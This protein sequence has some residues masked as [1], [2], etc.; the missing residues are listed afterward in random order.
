MPALKIRTIHDQE[1][2]LEP[3]QMEELA[4]SF[5]GDVVTPDSPGYDAA[6]SIWNAM[7]DRRPALI[8]RCAGV[9]DILA[10][11]RFA[12]QHR[13]LVSVRGGGHNIAGSALADGALLIDL[14]RMRSV[15]VDPQART[16]RVEPGATLA[17]FDH[18]AQAFGLATPL[19]INSTTG[20]A[21]LTLGGGFGW[22]SRRFG[23][24]IDNLLSAD[25]VTADG[26]LRRASE[27]ENP[28]LFWAIRGGGGNFGVVASFD[29]RLHA[30]GPDV[31]SGLVVHPFS[32]ARS[33]LRQYRGVVGRAPEE[34][35]CWAVLRKAPPLPFLPA[36]WH[37]KEV[38]VLAMAYAGDP[39]DGE[40]VMEPIRAVGHPIADVVGVNP[41]AGWQKAFDP[42]LVPG[43]RNYWKS[44]DLAALSDGAID[45]L[46]DFASRVPSPHCEVFVGHL[47]GA[48]NRVRPEATAF[49]RRDAEFVVNV[50]GRWDTAAE[51]AA[52]VAWCRDLFNALAPH[53]TGAVYV[54]FMTADEGDRVRAAYGTNYDRLMELKARYDPENVFR[55]NQ[56]IRPAVHA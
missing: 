49:S 9:A 27:T 33:V 35:S 36:E 2:V 34:L 12:R 45:T 18:E 1:I 48:V 24:T 56:N 17:D 40:L 5:R 29:F 19:G 53:A 7:I 44:H 54:N 20:V 46:L 8:A 50:H 26:E 3:A 51:D 16:A 41:F 43:A 13:L 30:L 11:V 47:G 38:V 23:L 28:D 6:R 15:R 39:R 52:G 14:S 22:I 32:D 37:G 55:S 25:V 31:L 21:G 42:L 4:S 10:A